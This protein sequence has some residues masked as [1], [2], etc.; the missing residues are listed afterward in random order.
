MFT[1]RSFLKR[2]SGAL[3][4]AGL[5]PMALTTDD[6]LVPTYDGSNGCQ[7]NLGQPYKWESSE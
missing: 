4:A 7:T 1:R 3:A 2:L 5:A 6:D